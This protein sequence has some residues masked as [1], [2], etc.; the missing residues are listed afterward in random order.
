MECTS[1]PTGKRGISS[2]V[3]RMA[4][5]VSSLLGQNNLIMDLL[6]LLSVTKCVCRDLWQNNK[7]RRRPRVAVLQ[8]QHLGAGGTHSGPAL[9]AG[10]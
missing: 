4:S 9:G 1:D 5:E 8:V 2:Q 7:C 6:H 3:E 10:V